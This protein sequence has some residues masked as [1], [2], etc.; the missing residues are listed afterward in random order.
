ME[1]YSHSSA[2]LVSSNTVAAQNWKFV[3]LSV[4]LSSDALTDTVIFLI[5]NTAEAPATTVSGEFYIDDVTAQVGIVGA[6]RQAD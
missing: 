3:A 5:D 2:A 4:Q 6:I 1:F